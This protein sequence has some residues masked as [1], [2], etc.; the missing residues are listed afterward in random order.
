MA[1]IS[2]MRSSSRYPCHR[3]L[4]RPA[5]WRERFDRHRQ[6]PAIASMGR[7]YNLIRETSDSMSLGSFIIRRLL[8]I[9]PV[10]FGITVVTFVVSHAVPADPIAANLGQ[11]AQEDP[12][13][14]QQYRHE[15][16]LDK[17]LPQQYTTYV[18]NILHGDMGISISTREPGRRRPEAIFSRHR[19]VVGRRRCCSHCWSAYRLA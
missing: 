2:G 15:W 3:D 7:E 17:S 1:G 5:V 8:L 11:R 4:W 19:G 12:A 14:I 6:A 18:W 9:I 16:G 13:I 10:L